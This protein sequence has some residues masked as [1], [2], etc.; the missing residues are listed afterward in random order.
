MSMQSKEGHQIAAFLAH[1]AGATATASQIADATAAAWH[2]I[3]A[4]LTPIIGSRGVA[5]LFK[6]SLH[7]NRQDH[8]CLA[9]MLESVQT[10]LDVAPLKSVLAQQSSAEAAAAGGEVLQTFYEL[11]SNLVG[12]SLTERLLRSVWINFLSGPA[13]EENTK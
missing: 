3:D 11:L 12:P 1:R 6:R 10:T 9:A 4:A 7:L 13:V 8:P 2:Q 5:A